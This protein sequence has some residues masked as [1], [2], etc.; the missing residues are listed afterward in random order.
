MYNKK[1]NYC[2]II[3]KKIMKKKFVVFVVFVFSITNI[4]SQIN[5]KDVKIDLTGKDSINLTQFDIFPDNFPMVNIIFS[6]ET[7]EGM[8][9]WNLYKE[10]ILLYEDGEKCIVNNLQRISEKEEINISFVLDHS[11]S[12]SETHSFYKNGGRVTPYTEWEE[13]EIDG[14]S[15]KMYNAESIDS[16]K[17][18][19]IVK[20]YP[21]ND[22]RKAIEGFFV[23]TE[24]LR[25]MKVQL[26]SFN[27]KVTNISK[28]YKNN[29]D[30]LLKKIDD[31]QPNGETA[32]YDA[33]SSSLSSL[34]KEEGTKV[35]VALTDGIDNKSASKYQ[36]IIK[37]AK[38]LDIPVYIIGYGDVDVQT[39]QRITSQTEGKF[40]Y[41]TDSK[42]FVEIFKNVSKKILS[43]Y[44]LSFKSKNLSSNK[45]TREIELRFY[46]DSIP[47]QNNVKYYSI[48]EKERRRLFIEEKLSEYSHKLNL[49]NNELTE[50]KSLLEFLEKKY[51]NLKKI[52][53]YYMYSSIGMF[54]L[55][56]TGFFVLRYQQK[57]TKTKTN[58]LPVIQSVF[59]NP[60]TDN[61]TLMYD[62]QGDLTANI[63]IHNVE[64]NLVKNTQTVDLHKT[65]INVTDLK[66]GVY[67]VNLNTKYPSN[68]IKFIKK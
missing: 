18:D 37:K 65:M 21:L 13:K 62:L 46:I 15:Y 47:M 16:S 25:D 7:Q 66:P 31:L 51:E 39:L 20:K 3:G 35:I 50:N 5:T 10:D 8:P 68:V 23:N 52:S 41:T 67:M 14:I 1:N 2:L 6:A 45:H 59:P 58:K 57:K 11:Y 28:F 36:D 44:E 32:F 38:L 63:T 27:T 4:F 19:K 42:T 48:S 55:L 17:F 40:Y 49:I 22:A 54:L 60:C 12:M 61:I 30:E 53:D 33:I 34:D 64:G 43:I 26:V 24:Y 9:I 56:A 29:Q